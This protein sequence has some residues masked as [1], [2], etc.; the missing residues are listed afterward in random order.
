M[1]TAPKR[2]A[3]CGLRKKLLSKRNYL[4]KLI[5]MFT[6]PKRCAICGLRKKL[7]LDF[8]FFIGKDESASIFLEFYTPVYVLYVLYVT[9]RA[10][11]KVV[12]ALRAPNNKFIW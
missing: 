9:N 12:G 4:E 11:S 8:N 1:F 10:Q 7:Y 5:K 3:I 2:C 6:T